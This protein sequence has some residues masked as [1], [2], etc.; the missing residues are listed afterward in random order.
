MYSNVFT[1]KFYK[2]EL[3]VCSYC[4][5]LILSDTTKILECGHSYHTE[6]IDDLF[7]QSKKCVARN[8]SFVY[9]SA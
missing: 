9:L 5:D 7:D 3:D 8:C 1:Y 6:C 2:S 4:E